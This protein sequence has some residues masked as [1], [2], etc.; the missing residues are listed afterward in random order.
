[1]IDLE[2]I[3]PSEIQQWDTKVI[4]HYL[5]VESKKRTETDSQTL[6]NL[7]LPKETGWRRWG[8]WVWDGNVVKV[9]CGDGCTT[10]NII[11]FI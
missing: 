7:Q 5:Y 8:A 6:K 3:M 10:I 11:K 4:C 2:I 9:G 1:M